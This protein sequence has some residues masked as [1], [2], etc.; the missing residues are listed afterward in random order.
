MGRVRR[1]SWI[2]P[3]NTHRDRQ[4]AVLA[5][6]HS[7]TFNPITLNP[8]HTPWSVI[9]QQQCRSSWARCGAWARWVR[10]ESARQPHRARL[11]LRSWAREGNRWARNLW[12]RSGKSHRQSASSRAAI[13]VHQAACEGL[14]Y[15]HTQAHAAANTQHAPT[16]HHH[17]PL[18]SAFVPARQRPV[19]RQI[20]APKPTHARQCC[21][22][23]IR[24]APA[25]RQRQLPQA[26]VLL[27]SKDSSERCHPCV[28]QAAA[29]RQAEGG[30]VGQ[31]VPGAEAEA[32]MVGRRFVECMLAAQMNVGSNT[33]SSRRRC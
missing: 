22:P 13:P 31:G 5:T 17:H 28:A 21:H 6:A 20:E 3:A 8:K 1:Q 18:S 29:A 11:R 16:P 7:N 23:I 25:A 10:A 9:L 27:L 14:A 24:Q 2:T 19:A 30:E 32:C 33:S 4:S 15:R 12:R 26:G